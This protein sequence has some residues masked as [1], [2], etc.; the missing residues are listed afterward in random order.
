MQALSHFSYHCSSGQFVLCDLQGGVYE[1]TVVLTD[2]VV[3]SRDGR[4]GAADLGH[5]VRA[6]LAEFSP[7]LARNTCKVFQK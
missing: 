2:P 4:Y 6:A 1:H 7:Q 3:C 5:R